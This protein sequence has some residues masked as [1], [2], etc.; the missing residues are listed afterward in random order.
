MQA[1][2]V[3]WTLV[4]PELQEHCDWLVGQ[5]VVATVVAGHVIQA[6]SQLPS[7]P[8]LKPA[9]HAHSAGLV[10]QVVVG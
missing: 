2:Q 3:P 5:A 1:E 10:G 9:L 6:F 8:L 7:L 4:N